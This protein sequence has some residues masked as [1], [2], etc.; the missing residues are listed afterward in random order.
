MLTIG[1]F[2]NDN[3]FDYEK[4]LEYLEKHSGNETLVATARR[5][6]GTRVGDTFTENAVS[7]ILGRREPTGEEERETEN[8][9]KTPAQEEGEKRG[10]GLPSG[11]ELEVF[12]ELKRDLSVAVSEASRLHASLFEAGSDDER[13]EIAGNILKITRDDLPKFRERID[14]YR[15]TAEKLP[16]PCVIVRAP[17]RDFGKVELLELIKI[18]GNL[19]SYI[20]RNTDKEKRAQWRADLEAIENEIKRFKRI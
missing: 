14:H 16:H 3:I 7:E 2:Y 8:P 10:N 17:S 5:L 12:E 9:V 4:A 13:K 15:N 1:D 19:T 11:F 18:K 20:S 6:A